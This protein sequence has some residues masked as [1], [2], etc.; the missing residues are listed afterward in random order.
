MPKAGQDPL[1]PAQ[2][3]L[4]AQVAANERW[5]RVPN[6]TEATAPG[7]DAFLAGFEKR[8]DPLGELPEG[9]RRRRAESAR[10]AHMQRLALASSRA[11][12][13]QGP[14]SGKAA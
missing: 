12:R 5:S 6:R 1:T 14:K 11:R 9:E 10:R 4:R 2:R 7:R 3:R 8:V 13:S